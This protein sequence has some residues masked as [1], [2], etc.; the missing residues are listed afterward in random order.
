[1]RECGIYEAFTVK[2]D[3]HQ[4]SELNSSKPI[5]FTATDPRGL[6]TR[7][8]TYSIKFGLEPRAALLLR[9]AN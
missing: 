9:I 1:M 5:A 2:V 7:L 6:N 4:L 8:L 3:Q